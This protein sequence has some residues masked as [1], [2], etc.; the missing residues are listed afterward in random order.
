MAQEPTL[1]AAQ[2]TQLEKAAVEDL[3]ETSCGSCHG[4]SA[5]RPPHS[6]AGTPSRYGTD[7]IVNIRD[8]DELIASG[9]ITPGFP[10][11][12][13]LLLL[14]ASGQMPPT[15]SGVPPVSGEDLRRVEKFIVRLDPP[16]RAEVLAILDRNCS[17][18]HNSGE[19]D[20]VVAINDILDLG[21]LVA[22]GLIVPGDRD[23][24]QLYTRVLDY[25]MPP[26]SSGMEP[27]SNHDLARL[28]GYIDLMPP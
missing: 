21:V 8:L 10:E 7:P 13:P 23:R 11:N 22:A 4:A 16:T 5:T 15:A 25:E 3:L 27:V 17:A 18:C 26:Q 12:S 14:M 20:A 28:G 1:S 9:L 2:Q 6:F 24:S 19:S